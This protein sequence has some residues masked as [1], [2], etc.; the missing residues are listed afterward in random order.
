V[1]TNSMAN[2][3]GVGGL[4]G[5]LSMQTASWG[6]F[7]LAMLTAIIVPFVLTYLMGKRKLVI[8]PHKKTQVVDL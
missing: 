2:S 3:I 4:P 6:S 8:T 7:A 1:S 5:I